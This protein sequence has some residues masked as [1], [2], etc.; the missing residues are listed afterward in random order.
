VEEAVAHQKS[1][2]SKPWN[3]AGIALISVLFSPRPGGI[4]HA[5]NYARLGR[6]KWRNLAL[7]SNLITT[8]ILFVAVFVAPTRMHVLIWATSLFIAA[9]FYK[10]QDQLFRQHKSTGGQTASLLVPAILS[11]V[12]PILLAVSL[13]YV[14]FVHY[15][16]KLKDAV[17]LMEAGELLKAEDELRDFQAAYPDEM[18]SYFNLALI[19]EKSGDAEKAKQELRKFLAKHKQSQEVREY[20]DRLESNNR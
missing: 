18:A 10:S 2:L 12:V 20:L 7:V 15:R 13:S 19:Y 14:E 8:T 17:R 1:S 3:P 5:L 11:I 16:A 4:L 6:P 9:Y